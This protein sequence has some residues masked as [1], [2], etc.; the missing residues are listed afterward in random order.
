[1]T[2]AT[3]NSKRINFWVSTLYSQR[4]SQGCTLV[5]YL[6]GCRASA[7]VPRVPPSERRSWTWALLRILSRPQCIAETDAAGRSLRGGYFSSREQSPPGLNHKKHFSH[8]NLTSRQLSFQHDVEEYPFSACFKLAN[9]FTQTKKTNVKS[10]H[11]SDSRQYFADVM[12]RT[13]RKHWLQPCAY[14]KSGTAEGIVNMICKKAIPKRMY[15]SKSISSDF[16]WNEN[17]HTII[18]FKVHDRKHAE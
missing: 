14:S 13:M 6:S 4:C 10:C 18:L 9:V 1:M 12:D 8:Q 2:W 7:A 15:V 17:M 5:R 3:E 11:S 16:P